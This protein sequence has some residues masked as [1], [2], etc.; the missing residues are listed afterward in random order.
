[1]GK[2]KIILD[3]LA[4]AFSLRFGKLEWN[5]FESLSSNSDS[6]TYSSHIIKPYFV[7]VFRGGSTL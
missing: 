2:R 5:F 4:L 7:L 3:T 1:M 6:Q